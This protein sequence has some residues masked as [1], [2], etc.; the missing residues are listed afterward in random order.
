MHRAAA[1]LV[2]ISRAPSRQASRT[3]SALAAASMLLSCCLPSSQDVAS[4]TA[5]EQASCSAES[6][7]DGNRSS[8]NH[9]CS[10]MLSNSAPDSE[11]ARRV[12]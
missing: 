6:H 4:S 8:L 1:P 2:A 12:S 9:I 3:S 5:Q 10:W 7:K 11:T